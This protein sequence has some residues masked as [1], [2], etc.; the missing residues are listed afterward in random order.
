MPT[1][2]GLAPF[3]SNS[4]KPA[5]LAVVRQFVA[6]VAHADSN[7]SPIRMR[8]RDGRLT[9]VLNDTVS[10]VLLPP[11]YTNRSLLKEY[12][13]SNDNSA[14]YV[15][16]D[17]FV[18]V[19]LKGLQFIRVSLRN[20]GICDAFFAFRDTVRTISDQNLLQKAEAW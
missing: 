17:T 8:C 18:D 6:D 7:P 1:E 15:G 14:L 2:H 20:R 16:L 3:A 12:I 5:A 11:R 13:I 9:D 10:V 19:L 4:A